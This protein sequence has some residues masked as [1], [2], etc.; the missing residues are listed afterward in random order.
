MSTDGEVANGPSLFAEVQSLEEAMKVFRRE[1]GEHDHVCGQP[2]GCQAVVTS[3]PF[4]YLLAYTVAAIH[5]G[6]VSTEEFEQL[7]TRSMEDWFQYGLRS[8]KRFG[9]GNDTNT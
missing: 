2:G 1:V 4:C 5:I 6:G 7:K 9:F 3:I 8:M